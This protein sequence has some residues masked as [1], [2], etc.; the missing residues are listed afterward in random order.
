LFDKR[1]DLFD[2]GSLLLDGRCQV[3]E[4]GH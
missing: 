4:T 3:L 1:R 2:R